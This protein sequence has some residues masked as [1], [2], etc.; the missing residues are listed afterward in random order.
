M[1]LLLRFLILSIVTTVGGILLLSRVVSGDGIAA[2]LILPV[3]VACAAADF[4]RT[5]RRRTGRGPGGF[6]TALGLALAYVLTLAGCVW[7]ISGDLSRFPSVETRE[8]QIGLTVF[9]GFCLLVLAVAAR[10]GFA[11]GGGASGPAPGAAVEHRQTSPGA[12][13]GLGAMVLRFMLAALAVVM[14]GAAI[15]YATGYGNLFTALIAPAMAGA[16]MVADFFFKRTGLALAGTGAWAV[17]LVCSVTYGVVQLVFGY[18]AFA[19][20]RMSIDALPWNVEGPLFVNI[21]AVAVA[22]LL[23]VV[24][25]TVRSF[26]AIGG[27]AARNAATRRGQPVPG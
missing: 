5:R 24:I 20:G 22:V 25:V 4:A 3:A 1:I 12:M 2:L 17:T 15:R 26:I 8:M 6:G 11:M 13:P 21:V 23:V 18:A 14:A 7:G 19:T 27:R 16:V 9:L 10:M